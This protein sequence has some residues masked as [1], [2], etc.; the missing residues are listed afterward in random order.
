MPKDFSARDYSFCSFSLS[1]VD[2]CGNRLYCGGSLSQANMQ[3]WPKEGG[4]RVSPDVCLPLYS[5]CLRHLPPGATC[6][7]SDCLTAELSFLFDRPC[8]KS[9][10]ITTSPPSPLP[11]SL[12]LVPTSQSPLQNIFLP[13]SLRII[14]SCLQRKRDSWLSFILL[15]RRVTEANLQG[16]RQGLFVKLLFISFIKSSSSPIKE[17]RTVALDSHIT[18]VSF[19]EMIYCLI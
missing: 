6:C 10:A 12:S 4:R 5:S 2:S 18:L 17:P 1:V 15:I 9:P 14:F 13:I 11:T 16:S 7:P 3:T 19:G 8:L